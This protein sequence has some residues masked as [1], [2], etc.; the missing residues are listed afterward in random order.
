MFSILGCVLGLRCLSGKEKEKD[1][2]KLVNTGFILRNMVLFGT[3]L[4]ILYY[5]FKIMNFEGPIFTS[6]DNPAAY[7]DSFFTRVPK[8]GLFTL[9]YSIIIMFP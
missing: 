8:S 3:G 4:V 7:S 1:W 2:W 5:R 6:I 9:I